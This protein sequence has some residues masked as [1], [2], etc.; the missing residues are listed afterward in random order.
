MAGPSPVTLATSLPSFSITVGGTAIDSTI[1]VVSIDIWQ[2]VNK[3]PMAQ[4]VISDG[5]AAD[6]TF[7]ISSSAVFVPGGVIQISIGYGGGLTSIFSGVIHRH[8]LQAT[9]NGPSRLVVEA[10]DKAMVLTLSRQSAVFSS[11]TD[12]ALCTQLIGNAGLTA[13]VTSTDTTHPAIVQYYSSNWDLIVTR[14]EVNGMVVTVAAG[15][16]TI[17]P[18][19]TSTDAV[20][21]LTYGESILDISLDMDASTQLTAGAIQSFGWDPATQAVVQSSSASA[22]VTT[23]GNISSDTLAE[24]FGVSPFTQQSGAELVQAD[25]TS[26]SNAELLKSQLAKIRGRVRFQGSALATVGSMVTLAGLGDRFNGDAYVSGVH[27]SLTEGLWRTTLELGLSPEWFA[28][29]APRVAAPGA[30]GQLP[31]IHAVQTG[32][33]KQINQ[34]P[35]GEYRVMVTLP[36]LQAA[37]GVWARFGSFYASNSFGSN[38]YPEI[39]DEV[40]LGFLNGDPRYPVILGSLYSKANPPPYPPTSGDSPAPNNTKSIMT[41]SKLHIDFVEDAPQ[42]LIATPGK[43][44]VDLNDKTTS[45]T[46]TDSNG[47]SITLNSSGIALKSASDITLTADGSITL[48]AQNNVSISATNS[49]TASAEASAKISATGQMQISG[50]MVQLNP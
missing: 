8:G 44:S 28:A 43:Q 15:T 33:V 31:P 23:P 10:T 30:S 9:I 11:L 12:S 26:W 41:K 16:V 45:I 3:L 18:P 14:A 35:D 36:L 13:D 2:G 48:T 4:L 6:Q 42:L 27:N 40:V 39:G 19:D 25:L 32:I 1:Q 24:V 38:F 20:L 22:S 47:N 49:L 46:I 5:A 37:D 21:T 17:A 34:D 29:T 7:A 50:A